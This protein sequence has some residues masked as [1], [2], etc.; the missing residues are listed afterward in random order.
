DGRRFE[1]IRRLEVRIEAAIGVHAGIEHQAEVVAMS[2]QAVEKFIS[3]FAELLL[4]LGIPEQ[5][6]AVLADGYVGVHAA[7]V[8]AH[9]WLRQERSGQAH[10]ARY[11]AADQLVEL[12]M[13]GGSY[14]FGV[15]V[16]D[17]ELRGRDLGMILFVLE[18]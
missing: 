2:E 6:L 18:A 16:I 3:E 7:A 4:A 9:H 13:V 14:G 10:I 8:D 17:F 11:L 1:L 12:N 15:A 5:V